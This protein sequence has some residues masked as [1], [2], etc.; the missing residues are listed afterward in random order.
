MFFILFFVASLIHHSSYEKNKLN[1]YV[2]NAYQEMINNTK[3]SMFEEYNLKYG[4]SEIKFQQYWEDF[5]ES[6][7]FRILGIK[8]RE[9]IKE[10][11]KEV[12]SPSNTFK[13]FG[14][15]SLMLILEIVL[16]PLRLILSVII[17]LGYYFLIKSIYNSFFAKKKKS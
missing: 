10:E 17:I 11:Y 5:Q 14:L 13:S 15:T 4:V 2:D 8:Y 6:E 1:S 3:N 9:E 16:T 7:D 12:K